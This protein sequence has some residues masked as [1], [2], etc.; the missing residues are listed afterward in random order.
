MKYAF[1]I[2]I[3]YTGQQ[4]TLFGCVNDIKR[5]KNVLTT[6]FNYPVQNIIELQDWYVPLG[7]DK[8][9]ILPTKQNIIDNLLYL[10][11]L[12]NT[13]GISELYFHYSGHGT[14][15]K[16]NSGDETDGYDE[17]LVPVDYNKSGLIL[18]DDLHII[19][20]RY[21]INTKIIMFMDCC[22]SGSILDLNYICI[23]TKENN[24]DIIKCNVDNKKS[25]LSN[26][27]VIMISGCCDSQTSAD[28]YNKSMKEYG[29]AMTT[30]FWNVIT[31]QDITIISLSNLYFYICNEL[32]KSGFTQLPNLS[33]S[34]NFDIKLPIFSFKTVDRPKPIILPITILPSQ[35]NTKPT[36]AQQLL[37]VQQ[38]TP[39]APLPQKISPKQ[40]VPNLPIVQT[41]TND[42][43]RENNKI[44]IDKILYHV[45]EIDKAVLF[46]KREI[47][48]LTKML[49]N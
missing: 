39:P 43:I 22:H 8:N 13:S 26:H 46:H 24:N 3:N 27:N 5:M 30:S 1:L 29:G 36:V 16:D 42:Q 15:I 45:E 31:T 33:M 11:Q 47:Y 44:I 32:L 2:G 48:N 21:N 18:D 7:A 17:A 38:Y 6:K 40:S 23:Y 20:A 14:S 9:K 19:F 4:N 35:N 37:P 28:F 25:K 41:Y 10:A 49:Y 12:S 34:K